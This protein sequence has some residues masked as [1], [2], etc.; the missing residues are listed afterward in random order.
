[1]PDD[2][3]MLKPGDAMSSDS[4]PTDRL[5]VC[6]SVCGVVF[7]GA[8]RILRAVVFTQVGLRPVARSGPVWHENS[9]YWQ[10]IFSENIFSR[11][12]ICC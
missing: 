8:E 10:L 7:V 12:R 3:L 5:L 9:V 11:R 2:K 4:D 6:Q 1:M